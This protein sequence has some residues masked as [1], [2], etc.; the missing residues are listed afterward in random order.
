MAARLDASARL[1]IRIALEDLNAAFSYYLDHGQVDALAALFTEDAVYTHGARRSEGRAEIEALLR[2]RTAAGPRTARHIY[3]GLRFQIEDASYATGTSV[4]LSFAADG[5]PPLPAT[6]F[7]VADFVDRY[8]RGTD[9]RWRFKS[10][11]IERIFVAPDNAGPVGH[12]VS[13]LKEPESS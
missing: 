6:P 1:A 4:C 13:A 8:E 12:N 3:S 11:H 5:L 9:G 2:K 7:L 10:R